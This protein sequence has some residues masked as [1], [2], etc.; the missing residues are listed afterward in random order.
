MSKSIFLFNSK[1]KVK[2]QSAR[3]RKKRLNNAAKL[4]NEQTGENK[5]KQRA[6]KEAE[7]IRRGSEKQRE[8]ASIR[9]RENNESLVNFS[10]LIHG[11]DG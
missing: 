1:K 11:S 7:A 2:Q 6:K 5:T 9:Q 10:I 4:K 3:K 8:A